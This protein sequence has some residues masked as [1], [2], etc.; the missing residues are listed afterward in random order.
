VASAAAGAT[1]AAAEATVMT[2]TIGGVAILRSWVSVK[3]AEVGRNNA[4]GLDLGWVNTIRLD[5]S[6]VIAAGPDLGW[7]I[8]V[9][10]DLGWE[11]VSRCRGRWEAWLIGFIN[12]IIK[13]SHDCCLRKPN[14]VQTFNIHYMRNTHPRRA[15]TKN[16]DAQITRLTL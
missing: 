6:R 2:S 8:T 3:Q 14:F 1:L 4:D 15:R 9:G 11:V 16:G 5:L 7:V 12:F 10:P 13:I